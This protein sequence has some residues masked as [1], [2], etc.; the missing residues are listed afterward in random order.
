M[1]AGDY[2]VTEQGFI[3]AL[4]ACSALG[5]DGG[6]PVRVQP[7]PVFGNIV[8][9]TNFSEDCSGNIGVGE[10]LSCTIDNVVIDPSPATLTVNKTIFGCHTTN[11]L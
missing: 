5:F 3:S 9:S 8:I 10:S 1:G 4:E 11:S 7:V 6:Q 2:N